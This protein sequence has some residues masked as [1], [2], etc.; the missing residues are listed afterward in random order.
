MRF[1]MAS[2]FPS[3]SSGDAHI[4]EESDY[5]YHC[6]EQSRNLHDS[7]MELFK[8]EIHKMDADSTITQITCS[9]SELCSKWGILLLVKILHYSLRCAMYSIINRI[10]LGKKSNAEHFFLAVLEV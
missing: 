10:Y 6:P 9:I 8:G 1:K 5:W 2:F 4:I 7:G 3:R